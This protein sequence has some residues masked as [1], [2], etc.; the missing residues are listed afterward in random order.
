MTTTC[1]ACG[2]QDQSGAF[3]TV[4][5]TPTV[6]T[7]VRRAGS[8]M[9]PRLEVTTEPEAREHTRRASPDAPRERSA[10]QPGEPPLAG[11]GRRV[12]AYALDLLAVSLLAG[13]VAAVVAVATGLPDRYAALL[14]ASTGMGADAAASELVSA[15]TA[16]STT[17]GLVSLA[18]WVAL[19]VWEGRT[20]AT[21]GNRLLGIRTHDAATAEPAGVGRVLLRWLVL[22]ISGVVP[23][24]GTVLVLLSPLFDPSGRRQGWHDRL[25]RT[26]VHDVRAVPPRTFAPAVPPASAPLPSPSPAQVPA[27]APAPVAAAQQ[28]PAAAPAASPSAAPGVAH[29]PWSFP[30]TPRTEQGGLITGVPGLSVPPAASPSPA[31]SPAAVEDDD[32]ELDESAHDDRA[33]DDH[34]EE[35][36]DVE[37]TRFSV[38]SRRGTGETAARRPATSIDLPSGQRVQ[39]AERTLVGRNPQPDPDRPA[40]LLRLED[41]TRSVSKTHLELV[42]TADGLVL[43]DLGSTNGTAAIAPDGEVRELTPGTPVTVTTGWAVQAGDLRFTVVGPVDA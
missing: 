42:P 22:W 20:G 40:A 25:A 17:V 8:A 21:V 30:A 9:S 36:E 26:V 2:A 28:V 11:V 31:P 6:A 33:L 24:V 43:T 34:P 15:A 37:A 4:C 27:A 32:R 16:V 23:V 19:A 10:A 38:S 5:G 3:C 41:P 14:E 39:V 12:G 1:A 18:A 29:D 35:V 13:A 7:G